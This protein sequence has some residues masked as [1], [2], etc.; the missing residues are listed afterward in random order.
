M[1]GFKYMSRL[2]IPVVLCLAA[3]VTA[4]IKNAVATASSTKVGP[5]IT[6][7]IY[8]SQYP[9]AWIGDSPAA[10]FTWNDPAG[11]AQSYLVTRDEALPI[12]STSHSLTWY[13]PVGAHKLTVR[14]LSS[15]G[16][17]GTPA[18]FRFTVATPTIPDTPTSLMPTSGESGPIVS[19][20]ASSADGSSFDVRF[21]ISDASGQAVSG[22]PFATVRALSGT[23]PGVE[24]PADLLAGSRD[25]TFQMQSCV[26]NTNSCSTLTGPTKVS[27]TNSAA[28]A[29]EET[30]TEELTRTL[31]HASPDMFVA[32]AESFLTARQRIALGL[33]HSSDG[34]LA[35]LSQS[36]MVRDALKAEAPTI[37]RVGALSVAYGHEKKM[38]PAI[39]FSDTQV[40]TAPDLSAVYVRVSAKESFDAI[41]AAG[42]APSTVSTYTLVLAFTPTSD[43]SF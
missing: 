3:T 11:G 36:A 20:L 16:K 17:A 22:A 37:E 2:A 28:T 8:S 19:G 24:I 14:P 31:G 9:V 38:R 15:D 34:A 43:G 41:D 21:F 42:A 40:T 29:D 35:Q 33:D 39:E 23:R 18:T 30:T 6:S 25:Y 5:N 7:T 13:P 1:F 12:T 32:A 26:P 27:P 10:D 4:T